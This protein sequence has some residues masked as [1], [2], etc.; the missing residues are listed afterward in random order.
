MYRK[1]INDTDMFVNLNQNCPD[2]L[3]GGKSICEGTN[4]D[5]AQDGE[6]VCIIGVCVCMDQRHVAFDHISCADQHHARVLENTSRAKLPCPPTCL[7][8]SKK[9]YCPPSSHKGKDGKCYCDDGS[10]VKPKFTHDYKLD[11]P[12]IVCQQDPVI[13][14]SNGTH[15]LANSIKEPTRFNV[16]SQG[17]LAPTFPFS[18]LIIPSSIFLCAIIG[19]FLIYWRFRHR[20]TTPMVLFSKRKW[21]RAETDYTLAENSPDGERTNRNTPN[22]LCPTANT[23]LIPSNMEENPLYYSPAFWF[24]SLSGGNQMFKDNFIAEDKIQKGI[25]IGNGQFGEVFKGKYHGQKGFQEVAIKVPKIILDTRRNP[26]EAEILKAFFVEAQITL[27]FDHENVLSCLGISTGPLGEPWMVVEYMRFGDLAEVLRANSGVLSLQH[28][29]SPTLE[30]IDMISIGHQIALG[31][32]YLVEQHFTHRDLA[33]RNC[34]VGGNLQVKISDFGLT[35]D[36]YESEYYR[37]SGTER[38]LPV[39][40]MAPESLTYGKFTSETDVWSYGVVLWEIFTFGKIPYYLS[41]NKEVMEDVSIGKHLDP[42]EGCP[43]VIKNLMLSCW[44]LRPGDRIK[45]SVIA[46]TLSKSNF[47]PPRAYSNSLYTKARKVSYTNT[48]SIFVLNSTDRSYL[49]MSPA[50]F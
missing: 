47:E 12:L 19:L 7:A 18:Y 40:W 5:C 11:L 48:S 45:F 36:I 41:S 13:K 21:R 3:N 14:H 6:T 37:V 49:D 28:S 43:D 34:L 8:T 31:M 1:D 29:T 42:P 24:E 27:G 30:M 38:L 35:R 10:W 20:G 4:C 32:N 22:I 23:V 16:T 39:R 46:K 17:I 9:N 26:I 44:K 25:R 50:S 2:V 33:A 15:N